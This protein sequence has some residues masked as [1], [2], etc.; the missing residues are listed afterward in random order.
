MINNCK[1]TI[2]DIFVNYLATHPTL[3]SHNLKAD[4]VTKF[5]FFFGKICNKSFLESVRKVN[6]VSDNFWKIKK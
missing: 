1:D 5:P 3:L 4:S 2:N 6:S